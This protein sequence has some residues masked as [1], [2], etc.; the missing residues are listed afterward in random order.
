MAPKRPATWPNKVATLSLTHSAAFPLTPSSRRRRCGA[1]RENGV[2]E[3]AEAAALPRPVPPRSSRC[4]PCAAAAARRIFLQTHADLRF[5]PAA[6]TPRQ[7][8]LVISLCRICRRKKY[9]IHD[10][11]D[12][13]Q[14]NMFSVLNF[15]GGNAYEQI[16][17]ATENFS[18]KY[19]IGAGGYVS[20]YVA[21]LSNGKNFAVKKI[22]AT[23][24]GRLIN[25]QMFYREIEAT[26]QIRHKNIVKVFGYCCTAR[27]KFIVYEYM[28]GGNLL[29]ALKSYRS[30]S[31]LDWKRRLCIAQDVAHA[32]SYLHHD[33]SDPIVH[34][35]VTTKNILLD[36]EFRACLSDFG[37]AKI[38]DADGSGHTRLAGTKG[39]LAP[40][41]AY[42]TK[43]T[44]KCD[45]YSFGVVVLELLMGSHPGDFVSSISCP[46]K[47]STPMKD[48]L[49]TRL[50]PPEGEVASEIFGLITV[51]IQC[52]HPNPSTRPTMPSAIHLFS[53]FSRAVDLDYLHADIM[54]FCLL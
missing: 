47:K 6:T 45:I 14:E 27:D 36:L 18:E 10:A 13:Q 33:C 1:A 4:R 16:I 54:E 40:E 48:L 23:E 35:D 44:E 41:L 28:K 38:L 20:V 52:L 7:A 25:E 2:I 51:A 24:N 29:T 46:S 42:T 17:E 53:K 8:V 26:M 30:A 32:L 3:A 22:N 31:E 43:V 9:K 34:R 15:D 49:D 12:L 21:K 19:C 5:F 50:P 37:I 39:Y 11:G